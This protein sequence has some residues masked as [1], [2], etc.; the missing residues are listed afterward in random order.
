MRATEDVI[1]DQLAPRLELLERGLRA[2]DTE[3]HLPNIHGSSGF[4]DIIARD[5]LGNIVLIELKRSDAASREA[6]HE[7]FKYVALLRQNHRVPPHRIRCMVVSTEWRELLVPFSSYAASAPYP[8]EGFRLCVSKSGEALSAEKVVPLPEEP[9][10]G[11]SPVHWAACCTSQAQR[12]GVYARLSAMLTSAGVQDYLVFFIDHDLT[13]PAVIHPLLCYVV[14]GRIAEPLRQRMLSAN[15]LEVADYGEGEYPDWAVEEAIASQLH[16]VD[17]YDSAEFP[18]P[19]QLCGMLNDTW[20]IARIARH[21]VFASET[22]YPEPMLT[23][24]ATAVEGGNAVVFSAVTRPAFEAQWRM[25]LEGLRRTLLGNVVWSE[26]VPAYLQEIAKT[27]PSATV[28][29]HVYNPMNCLMHLNMGATLS[30][31]RYFPALQIAA[32]DP[33]TSTL[34]LLRGGWKWNG[35]APPPPEDIINRAFGDFD[36][37]LLAMAMHCTWETDDEVCALHGL[38]YDL[39]EWRRKADEAPVIRTPRSEGAHVRW[40]PNIGQGKP[41]REFLSR[42]PQYLSR[43][44]D[45]FRSR[46]MGSP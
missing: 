36:R 46:T 10:V 40:S 19:E 17:G 39:V 6:I 37:F 44:R 34:C 5:A 25:L 22:I 15:T 23:A 18:S 35:V 45:L 24:L 8:V 16:V 41:L 21:G 42:N 28:S 1:R 27:L 2:L 4:V 43:L 12:N 33:A 29:I 14:L 9:G 32:E 26:A 3:L 31:Q 13:H 30:D 20:R 11:L 7:L 38:H